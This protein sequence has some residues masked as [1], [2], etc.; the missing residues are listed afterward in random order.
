[1]NMT[2]QYKLTVLKGIN[3]QIR[4]DRK[5]PSHAGLTILEPLVS[6][7]D[8][9]R[10]HGFSLFKDW[11]SRRDQPMTVPELAALWR[12]FG[13]SWF[14]GLSGELQLWLNSKDREGMKDPIALVKEGWQI[15]KRTSFHGRSG[16]RHLAVK[17]FVVTIL[18][19]GIV[20]LFWGSASLGAFV[21]LAW[22]LAYFR[23]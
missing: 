5:L 11:I 7:N 1:M 16:P 14:Q 19:L 23:F 20:P 21:S 4:L 13:W 3:P 12:H 2:S 18:C 15:L 9:S 10:A 8:P 17:T 22:D 6:K